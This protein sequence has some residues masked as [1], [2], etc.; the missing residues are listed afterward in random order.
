M[1]VAAWVGCSVG[2]LIFLLSAYLILL[3]RALENER[4]VAEAIAAM[5]AALTA[6]APPQRVLLREVAD[7]IAA[8]ERAAAKIDLAVH[9]MALRG[10]TIPPDSILSDLLGLPE[11]QL[12]VTHFLREYAGSPYSDAAFASVASDMLRSAVMDTFSDLADQGL[13]ELGK[14]LVLADDG[15]LG[16]VALASLGSSLDPNPPS[17]HAPR[18]V[19]LDQGGMASVIQGLDRATRR[20]LRW[21]RYCMV[22]RKPCCG[23]RGAEGTG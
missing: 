12:L 6:E 2:A 7:V 4:V 1:G 23:S 5:R 19:D 16:Q 13:V 17:Q 14:L 20:Q 18:L 22:R 10:E 8:Q 21:R 3:S 15:H 11:P 9:E